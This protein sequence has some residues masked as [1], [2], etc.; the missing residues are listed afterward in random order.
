[1]GVPNGPT[2]MQNAYTILHCVDHK[3]GCLRIT[4]YALIGK[5]SCMSRSKKAFKDFKNFHCYFVV[6][7][8]I[9]CYNIATDETTV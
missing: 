8:A 2:L 9:V 4:C 1:M 5:A 3:Y 6:I 7:K